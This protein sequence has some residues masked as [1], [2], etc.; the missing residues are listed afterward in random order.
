M[1]DSIDREYEIFM[2]EYLEEH[3]DQVEEDFIKNKLN[4][5]IPDIERLLSGNPLKDQIINAIKLYKYE[6]EEVLGDVVKKMYNSISY[7]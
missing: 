6:K 7:R 2:L 5:T 3:L 1:S 4:E